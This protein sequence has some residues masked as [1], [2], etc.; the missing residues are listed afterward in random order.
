MIAI[1]T[2]PIRTGKTTALLSA[3]P[4]GQSSGILQPVAGGSRRVLCLRSGQSRAL[5]AGAATPEQDQVRVGR[6]TFS[7]STL[8]WANTCV[9]DALGANAGERWIVIDEVGPLELRGAGI[10]PAVREAVSRA[11]SPGGPRV[12]LVVRDGLVDA[13]CDTFGIAGPRVLRLGDPLPDGSRLVR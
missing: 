3:F 2:G 1:F 5:E 10:A 11:Q 6:F 4:P 8:A 12:L 7:A 9:I 13:V